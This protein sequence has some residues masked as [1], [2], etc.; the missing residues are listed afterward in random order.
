MDKLKK[1][2]PLIIV[3]VVLLWGYSSFK[4]F[5]NSAVV[6]QEDAKTAWSNVESSYQ[7]RADLIPNLVNTV[8]GYASHESETLEAVIKARA[9]AT[10]TKIDASNLTEENMAAYQKAQQGLSGAL[11]RLMVV[12][13]KYPDLKANTNFLELQS[14]L[15]GTENRINVER[16]R[17]NGL[18]NNYNKHI[19]IFPNSMFAGMLNFE[20]MSRYKSAEGSEKAPEVKF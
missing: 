20:E 19:K 4:G 15:E 3:A 5:N 10:S 17:F 7:R 16:N 6:Y 13:E 9:S 2:L 12:S 18:V 8:K 14:Q 11:G 1:W